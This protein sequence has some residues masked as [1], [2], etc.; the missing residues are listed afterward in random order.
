MNPGRGS[1]A[2]VVVGLGL[3]AACFGIFTDAV[4]G[5]EPKPLAELIG[6]LKDGDPSVRR[7]AA[8][9]LARAKDPAA[10]QPL[11]AALKDKDP[12]V[13][14]YTAYAL[15]EIGDPRVTPVLIRTLKTEL[16]M[17][18]GFWPGLEAT[19]PLIELLSDEDP[20]VRLWAIARLSELRDPR[21]LKALLAATK[22]AVPK[23]RSAALDALSTVAGKA[24]IEPVAEVLRSADPALRC[25]AAAIALASMK[26]ARAFQPLLDALKNATPQWKPGVVIAL[27]ELGDPRAVEC[28]VPELKDRDSYYLARN[29]AA[30]ALGKIKDPRAFEPLVGMLNQADSYFQRSAALVRGGAGPAQVL[31]R[32]SATD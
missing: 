27:G 25:Q 18:M 5:A 21:S 22:D 3:L 32:R 4:F 28:L 17:L 6:K 19:K 2:C 12:Q 16:S 11:I 15:T 26:D 24:S 8:A 31:R 23:V 29:F 14:M 7:N 13:R 1:L 9:E 30:E 10:V 20:A